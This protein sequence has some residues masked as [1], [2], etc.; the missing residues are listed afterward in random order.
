MNRKKKGLINFFISIVP[1]FIIFGLFQF[2]GTLIADADVSN[3]QNGEIASKQF[4]IIMLFGLIGSTIAVW[5][6][7]KFIDK[8]PFLTIGFTRVHAAKDILLGLLFGFLIMLAGFLLL[9]ATGQISVQSSQFN[10]KELLFTLGLFVFVA[11]SEEL[12]FRGY[13][14]NNLINSFDRNMALTISALF[15]AVVHSINP[16]F[17]VAGFI[18]IFIAGIFLGLSY[19]FAKSL[20]FPIALHFSWNFFQ[21]LFGFNVSGMNAYS[22]F[23]TKYNVENLWNGG[24][25][26]FESSVLSFI[27]QI[28]AIGAVYFIFQ[29]RKT[30]RQVN[31]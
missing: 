1:Y 30:S 8:K 15:F 16:N 31:T 4:F 5:L 11:I 2:L 25:F 20:W 6:F 27:F 28:I 7:R 13:V 9:K 26:G 14:L 3:I 18:G 22:Y 23:N 24:A 12:Y 19:T 29:K 10:F 17:S 21:S